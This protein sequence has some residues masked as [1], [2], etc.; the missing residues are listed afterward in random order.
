MELRGR[1]TISEE[2]IVPDGGS[3]KGRV[4][5]VLEQ[6]WPPRCRSS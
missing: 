6:A 3:D 4:A 5:I 1:L 2:L